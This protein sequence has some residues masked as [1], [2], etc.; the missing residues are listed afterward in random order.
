MLRREK[1]GWEEISHRSAKI[2]TFI[3]G[4]YLSLDI[5]ASHH[6]VLD[7]A[8]HERYLKTTLYG[9]TSGAPSCV[10]LVIGAN[11]GVIGMSKEH[12]AVALALSVP[13]VVCITKV[14]RLSVVQLIH[15]VFT[16]VASQVDMTPPNKLEETLSQ[17]VKILR[18]RGCRRVLPLWTHLRRFHL[19][20]PP[21]GRFLCLSSLLK[22]PLRFRKSMRRRSQNILLSFA[23]RP[24]ALEQNLPNI[25]SFQCHGRRP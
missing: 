12:L 7:L 23:L 8:G 22:L 5:C 4:S 6:K 21:P 19:T 16:T 9:L 15:W 18:S 1:L 13:I 24:Y 2:V 25:S 14:S 17:V 11:A 10:I 20:S 3:G